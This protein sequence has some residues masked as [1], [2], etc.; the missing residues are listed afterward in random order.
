MYLIRMGCRA[1]IEFF[2]FKRPVGLHR[3][4]G[5]IHAA[6]IAVVIAP[7]RQWEYPALL[8]IDIG[9]FQ[10]LFKLNY[11][12]PPFIRNGWRLDAQTS[13]IFFGHYQRAWV[14]FDLFG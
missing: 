13:Q 2:A 10:E 7:E 3:G 4:G 8:R 5:D 9:I 12:Q 11:V 14:R 1:D 6:L